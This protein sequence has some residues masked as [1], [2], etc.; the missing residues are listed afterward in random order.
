MYVGAY[1]QAVFSFAF[2][3]EGKGA[4]K[5]IKSLGNTFGR[6]LGKKISRAVVIY[7]YEYIYSRER[8]V[9]LKYPNPESCETRF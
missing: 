3:K 9:K 5:E 6:K 8:I 7:S 4:L 1:W 2:W